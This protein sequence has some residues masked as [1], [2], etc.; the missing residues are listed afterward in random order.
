VAIAVRHDPVEADD[1]IRH[2]VDVARLV[3]FEEK[4]LAV[5]EVDEA[6][7]LAGSRRAIAVGRAAKEA[8]LEPGD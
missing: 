4:I 3:A 7:L 6:S 8:R 1:A 2:L 5:P